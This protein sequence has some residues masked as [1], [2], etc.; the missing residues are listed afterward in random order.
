M[1]GKRRSLKRGGTCCRFEKDKPDCGDGGSRSNE[2]NGLYVY[3]WKWRL[4]TGEEINIGITRHLYKHMD[5]VGLKCYETKDMVEFVKNNLEDANVFAKKKNDKAKNL[6][7]E[8]LRIDKVVFSDFVNLPSH[9]ISSEVV[10][11]AFQPNPR[12]PIGVDQSAIKYKILFNYNNFN[13]N[14]IAPECKIEEGFNKNAKNM[15]LISVF[16]AVPLNKGGNPIHDCAFNDESYI[17]TEP[18]CPR[19]DTTKAQEKAQDQDNVE[20]IGDETEVP[21]PAPYSFSSETPESLRSKVSYLS[22]DSDAVMQPT[23]PR[24]KRQSQRANKKKRKIKK[25]RKNKHSE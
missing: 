7:P 10:Y 22:S 21:E 16:H 4:K 3:L 18:P 11:N 19:K 6:L 15:K 25:S 9:R 8:H 14:N 20:E 24:G 23:L 5:S 2:N 1:T 12:R 17:D 13:K